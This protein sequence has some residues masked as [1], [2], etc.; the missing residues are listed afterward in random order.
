M[1]ILFRMAGTAIH[2]SFPMRA[3]GLLFKMAESYKVA[4]TEDAESLTSRSVAS[5][6]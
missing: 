1:Y 4:K 3:S 5:T 6:I 2:I